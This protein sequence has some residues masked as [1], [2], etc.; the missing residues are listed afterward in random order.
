M[1]SFIIIG[2]N[3]GWKLTKCLASVFKTIKHNKLNDYEVIYVDSKSTDDSI[4]KAR[5]FRNVLIFQ[6][7]GKYNAAIA[8]NLGAKEAKGD[9]LFFID[10]DMEIIP[11]FIQTVYHENNGL[12]YNF[13]SGQHENYY[14]NDKGKISKIERY[15]NLQKENTYM[16]TTGG[17]FLIKKELW[18]YV[19]GMKN[20]Y[21]KSEDLDLA[22]RL[23]KKG[24]KLVRKK[25][26]LAKHYTIDYLDRKRIWKDFFKGNHLY[27]RSMLYRDHIL[28]KHVYKTIIRNDYSLVIMIILG[29]ISVSTNSPY[30]MLIYILT[31]LL[32]SIKKCNDKYTLKQLTYY[33][34]RDVSVL[35][36]F[37]FFFPKEISK[38]KI[39]YI[40]I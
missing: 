3:E 15:F 5:K 4:D 36:G 1:I 22:L 26:L 39:Q 21:K 37:L 25:K 32:R 10:G 30:P 16:V 20:R 29:I 7:T 35:L 24:F 13:V 8:R 23:A 33:I 17:L 31:A 40:K 34:L 19:H 28:N 38:D 14:C 9:V 18:N 11:E 27:G 6:I 12:K 2:R